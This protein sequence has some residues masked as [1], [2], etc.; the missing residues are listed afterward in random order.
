[1][2]YCIVFQ[3]QTFLTIIYGNS[4][5]GRSNKFNALYYPVRSLKHIRDIYLSDY[6]KGGIDSAKYG[7]HIDDEDLF[8]MP[9]N[10]TLTKKG[11]VNVVPVDHFLKAVLAIL[12]NSKGNGIYHIINHTPPNME[13]LV[14]YTSRF[15]EVK[16]FEVSYDITSA[17]SN[18]AE[19]LFQM[20]MD[21]YK[22]YISDTRTFDDTNMSG[23]MGNTCPQLTWEVFKRCLDY[24]VEVEWGKRLY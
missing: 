4:I 18:P 7:F 22:P 16:G 8:N 5:T 11:E 12:E 10:L 21:P 1:M 2:K 14:A 17:D 15:L 23:L 9:V 6:R 13:T 3:I 24:A 19:E 20:Y